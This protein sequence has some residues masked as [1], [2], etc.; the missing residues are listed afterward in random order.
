MDGRIDVTTLLFLVLA[1][2]IFLKL[3]SVLGRRTGH[4]EARLERYKAQKEASQRNGKLAGQEKVV[5]LPRREREEAEPRPAADAQAQADSEQR[6]KEYA[7]GNAD[8][9]KGLLDIVRVDTG[10]DPSHFLQGAK[11]AY[12]IIV[13]AFAEG[14]RKTLKDLLSPEVFE[15][16]SSAI[17]E[18]E[19]RG[20]QIDQSFVGIKSADLVEAELKG[21]IAQLTIKFV[22]E[23]ISATR[24]K[25]G[26]VVNGDPKRIREV[27]DIW[28]F[29]REAV[30]RNPNWK[31]VATQAAN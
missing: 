30:S 28:T 22:S 5:T 18:R 16:F 31:L 25:A 6:V 1:V 10:F 17:A 9:A 19:N 14:N 3:R 23:L 12:E 13:T 2:V 15:G 8:M 29:A 27:T 11:A 7:A 21:G 4:E 26:G 24:D 20:E